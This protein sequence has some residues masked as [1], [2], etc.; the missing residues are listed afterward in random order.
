MGTTTLNKKS[1][2]F[3]TVTV[4]FLTIFWL[5]MASMHEAFSWGHHTGSL[6]RLKTH[7]SSWPVD[8][9]VDLTT[10]K[11]NYQPYYTN[12]LTFGFIFLYVFMIYQDCLNYST[13]FSAKSWSNFITFAFFFCKPYSAFTAI[14]QYFQWPAAVLRSHMHFC[15]K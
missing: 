1:S 8:Y 2:G 6:I 5:K 15:W 3:Y 9:F 7:Y 10:F 13:L 4:K 12:F 11:E 14:C